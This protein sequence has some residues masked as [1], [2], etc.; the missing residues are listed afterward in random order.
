MAKRHQP[1]E[2][3]DTG[4]TGGGIGLATLR[5]DG[6]ASLDATYQGGRVTKA[7]FITQ[8]KEL[9]INAKADVGQLRVEVLDEQRGRPIR[10]H[11]FLENTRFYSYRLAA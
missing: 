9:H 2:G 6:F 11:F 4:L 8:G 5:A 1:Y 10:L 7:L 3:K